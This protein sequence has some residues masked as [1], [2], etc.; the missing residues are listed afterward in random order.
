MG[1]CMSMAAYCLQHAFAV[2]TKHVLIMQFGAVAK[3]PLHKPPLA[4]S[5]QFGA[6]AKPPLNNIIL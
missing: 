5:M 2:L 6:V 1:F 4:L 3:P